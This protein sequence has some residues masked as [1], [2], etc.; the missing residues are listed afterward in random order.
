MTEPICADSVSVGC[1]QRVSCMPVSH[2]FTCAVDHGPELRA[3]RI[4][5]FGMNNCRAAQCLSGILCLHG[6]LTITV[7]P[8]S[9]NTDSPFVAPSM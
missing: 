9:Q 7:C 2:R 8:E 5:L 6:V 4:Q 1:G 3:I